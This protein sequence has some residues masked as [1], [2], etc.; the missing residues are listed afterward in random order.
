MRKTLKILHTLAA[1]GL[2]GGLGCYMI[3]LVIAPQETPAAYADMRQSIAAV[4]SYVLVPSL[5]VALVSGLLSMAMHPPFLD[6]RW[7]WLKAVMGF[8]LFKSVL[9]VIDARADHAAAISQEVADG[10][11]VAETLDTA[12]A[13]EWYALG[14]VMALSVAN[15]VVGIWRPRLARREQARA[16]EPLART[17]TAP[18]SNERTRPAA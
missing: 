5:G 7:A 10:A 13:S 18:L 6:K 8:I 1:C 3:L 14:I 12:L 4:S 15:V 11:P 17:E 2:I 9:M 16:A